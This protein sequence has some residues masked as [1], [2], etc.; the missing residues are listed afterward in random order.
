M[1]HPSGEVLIVNPLQHASQGQEQQGGD[2][3]GANAA[4]WRADIARSPLP[5]SAASGA[6]LEVPSLKPF[7]PALHYFVLSVLGPYHHPKPPT[8]TPHFGLWF[9]V[10]SFGFGMFGPYIG[11][12]G[13]GWTTNMVIG[14]LFWVA[15]LWVFLIRRSLAEVLLDLRPV[16]RCAVNPVHNSR[17]KIDRDRTHMS[18]L[19]VLFGGA[20]PLIIIC[21]TV[22][23]LSDFPPAF[24]SDVG[25]THLFYGILSGFLAF[26]I[27]S[28]LL[29]LQ[30]ALLFAVARLYIFRLHYLYSA[31]LQHNDDE[32]NVLAAELC[33]D[34][35]SEARRLLEKAPPREEV[36]P[37]HDG[38]VPFTQRHIA[39][40][41]SSSSGGGARSERLLDE[42]QLD[43]FLRVYRAIKEEAAKHALIWSKPLIVFLIAYFFVFAFTVVTII[44]D[45]INGSS[46]GQPI[47]LEVIYVFLSLLYV[48]V[49][50]T[51][52]ISINSTWPRLMGKPEAMLSKWSPQE[53]L[54]LNAYFTENPI[55]F[56]VLGI[57]FSWGQV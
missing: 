29:T 24:A 52:I 34:T 2:G 36:S 11:P 27:V 43:T 37:L 19:V 7:C 18:R 32:E 6:S 8:I 35:P 56:P 20:G 28:F 31:L 4:D 12:Y 26:F 9:L 57:A 1:S 51:P 5:L 21:L 49:N 23:F 50:L 10:C 46:K 15:L 47:R 17:A 16:L 53:R 13:G 38:V 44:R 14:C 41:S 33:C 25:L 55:V 40:S 45:M 54:I 30:L 3:G 22:Y 39:P 42:S 48:I